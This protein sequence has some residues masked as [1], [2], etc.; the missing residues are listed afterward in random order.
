[1]DV[2]LPETHMTWLGERTLVYQ[3]G[4]DAP[5]IADIISRLGIE[6]VENVVPVF[7]TVAVYFRGLADPSL[8]PSEVFSQVAQAQ[9][10]KNHIVPVL[11]GGSD[12]V[13]FVC[14]RLGV[15]EEELAEAH[16]SATY[17]CKA[18]G[19]CPGFPYLQGNYEHLSTLP[20]KAVPAVRVPPGS[21]ALM[22]SMTGIYP[23]ERPGGW[24]LIGRTPLM[25]ADESLDIFPIS[26]GDTVTFRP[27]DSQEFED[28]KGMRLT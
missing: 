22:G 12:D 2:S 11:Y 18:I 7:G 20:R 5:A 9:R 4:D 25:I 8:V 6:Q 19:F 24:W 16:S 28:L 13:E 14:Q 15:D 1:M 3:C 10:T 21:V 27:I 17:L 26:V 23:I